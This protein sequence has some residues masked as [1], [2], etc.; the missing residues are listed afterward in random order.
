MNPVD[1]I[2]VLKANEAALRGRGVTH[3]ALFG[4]TA[5]GEAHADSDLDI[6]VD[7]D[8]GASV[9]LYGYVGITLFIGDLFD[10]PVDVSQRDR[11]HAPV[12]IAAEKDA[13][14]AF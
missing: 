2:A 9:D 3:A 1:V 13:I 8:P 10:V 4:S 12:R 7:I 5:R 11:L 6:M 14:F